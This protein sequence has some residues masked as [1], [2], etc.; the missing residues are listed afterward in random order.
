MYSMIYLFTHVCVLPHLWYETYFLLA[1]IIRPERWQSKT[2]F[3]SG[4][5]RIKFS[6]YIELDVKGQQICDTWTFKL[7]KD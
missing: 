7:I 3:H 2:L 1:S 5:D 6:I 4:L